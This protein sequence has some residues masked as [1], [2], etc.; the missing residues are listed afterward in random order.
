MKKRQFLAAL[1]ALTCAASMAVPA[2]AAADTQTLAETSA[3]VTDM[4]FDDY[5]G[6]ELEVNTDI[7]KPN[8]KVTLPGSTAVLINPYRIAITTPDGETYDT[9]ISPEMEIVN[10]SGCAIKVGVKGLLQTYTTVTAASAD[11]T[12]APAGTTALD[13][14]DCTIDN[15]AGD[16]IDPTK[17]FSLDTNTKTIVDIN[18]KQVTATLT[19]PKYAA[20]GTT[21]ATQGKLVVTGYTASKDIK[22]ATAAMKDPDL[23][24]S[25]T[26]FVYVEGKE[27]GG[28]WAAAFDA[29]KVATGA[30]A[31]TGMMALSAKET[32]ANIL[33]LAGG[34]AKGYAR[35]TG[36]AAT[37]P[38]KA[39]MNITDTFDAD[40]TF[41]IDAVAN[42]APKA[43]VIENITATA[44]GSAT[45][46]V[47]KTTGKTNEFDVAVSGAAQYGSVQF[48]VTGADPA[49]ATVAY[50]WTGA[51]QLTFATDTLTVAAAPSATAFTGDL[52]ITLTS[53][54]MTSTY[55]AHVSVTA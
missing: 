28:E 7:Q 31:A 15:K 22:V 6:Y 43:P 46:T 50:A 2:F 13:L 40:F 19:A 35:V 38:T 44:G 1:L 47:T 24:K 55:I 21:V 29:K 12:A 10:N 41:V 33:Y 30:S 37:A 11:G 9:V 32:T 25:N 36:D 3:P 20:D 51:S 34:G 17:L 14:T 48:A 18:G 5:A 4:D 49:D 54:G 52:T 42:A 23:E 27:D 53:K 8:L 45:A 16:A 39:W 26:L